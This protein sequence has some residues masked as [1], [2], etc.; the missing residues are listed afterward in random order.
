M[1]MLSFE[2]AARKAHGAHCVCGCDEAGRGPLA[3]PVVAAAVYIPKENYEQLVGVN[4][5]KKLSEKKRAMF[6]DAILSC[7]P[8]G[9]GILHAEAIDAINIYEASRQAMLTAICNLQTLVPVDYVLSD[10]MP[11]PT[12]S[13]PHEAIIK[14]DQKSLSIAA[15]S[16][17]AKQVRDQI[18]IEYDKL[19]PQYAFAQHK[20]Y[21]T[22]KHIAALEMHG[23]VSGLHRC[24]YKPVQRIVETL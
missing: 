19:H 9:L 20:G 17:I 21:G 15:A 12:L 6:F 8:V 3:G 18:M 2:Q 10:A 24:S 11:L 5:S 1:D 22:K 7:C 13:L 16:I 14:G 4:D 23:I